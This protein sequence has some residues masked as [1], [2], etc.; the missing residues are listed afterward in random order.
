MDFS[1]NMKTKTT[2]PKKNK[3]NH[4]D[5]SW[6]LSEICAIVETDFTADMECHLLPKARPY[7]QEEAKRMAAMLA[8]VYSIAHRIHCKACRLL[9]VAI[10]HLSS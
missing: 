1:K 9:S 8:T 6:V 4:F 2:S 10:F 7:T 5:Y 3:I